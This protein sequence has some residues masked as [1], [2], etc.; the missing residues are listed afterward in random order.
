M[1]SSKKEK[2]KY[3]LFEVVCFMVRQ[4]VQEKSMVLLTCPLWAIL[5]AALS[6][7]ELYVT[8][9]ILGILERKESLSQ[10]LWAV[11]LF[12]LLL[13]LLHGFKEYID[14]C[15][16]DTAMMLRMKFKEEISLKAMRMAYPLCYDEKAQKLYGTAEYTVRGNTAAQRVWMYLS[17]FGSNLIC[18]AVYLF[19]VSALHPILLAVTVAVTVAGYFVSARIN[20]WG[21]RHREE[22]EKYMRMTSYIEDVAEDY[23][24]A[25]DMR[26]FGMQSWLLG[27][28]DKYLSLY[29]NFSMRGEKVYFCAD[30]IDILLSILRNGIA[31][32]YL[33]T[34]TLRDGLPASEFLLYFSAITGFTAWIT[35]ILK[36]YTNLRQQTRE[37][38][39]MIEFLRMEEPFAMEQGKKLLPELSKGYTLEMKNVSFRYPNAER[40]VIHHLN[41]TIKAG[42]RLAMVGLNGAGK[43]T[44]IKLLCGMYDPTEGAVLLNGEDIRQY[45]RRDYYKHF[46]AV[47]QEFS[48]LDYTVAANVSNADEYDAKRVWE[49]LETAGLAEKFRN[50]DTGI[51]TH[52]GRSIYEDGISL[53][54]GETQ[55]LMFARALYRNAPI[56]IL[57]EPTAA[58]DPIAEADTYSRYDEVSAGR[59]CIY[60][61]HRLAS[62]RFCDRIIYL[63]NGAITEEGTHESLLKAGGKYAEL[64][65]VQSRYYTEGGKED[66]KEEC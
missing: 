29:R 44:V 24:A 48:V 26:I 25:K 52:I 45:D 28:F 14:I 21:Y 65:A 18:F 39:S 12:S 55:K 42:E 46:S 22:R 64:F 32:A 1:K 27:I 17:E 59:T 49:C 66:G 38:S 61:S 15:S 58:L 16:N 4:A 20:E 41:L 62:T 19:T 37:L 13:I 43:T 11:L 36:S 2:P 30:L 34:V 9:S 51:E 7:T 5:P 53:S 56:L 6:V 10:L 54:G 31:Y 23:T 40:D 57:D 3:N 47:M 63:E 50:M 8:P 33:L 60:I 35:G